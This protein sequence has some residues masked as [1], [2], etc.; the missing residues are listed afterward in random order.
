MLKQLSNWVYGQILSKSASLLLKLQFETGV[1][2]AAERRRRRVFGPRRRA[3]QF[4]G[5]VNGVK[6]IFSKFEFSENYSKKLMKKLEN[7]I[8]RILHLK[9]AGDECLSLWLSRAQ[10]DLIFW[11]PKTFAE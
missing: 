9:R 11:N 10:I 5:G 4:I 8:E 3:E 6:V 2:A 1:C 7:Y